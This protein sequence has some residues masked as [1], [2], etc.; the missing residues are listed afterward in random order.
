MWSLGAAHLGV[1]VG[2]RIAVGSREMVFHVKGQ[3]A[4]SSC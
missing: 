1:V 2:I 3:P 4:L